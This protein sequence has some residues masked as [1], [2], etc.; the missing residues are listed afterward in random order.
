MSSRV[1]ADAVEAVEEV[2]RAVGLTVEQPPAGASYDLVLSNPLGGRV[3]IALKRVSLVSA[4]DRIGGWDRH[5][6]A[7]G[8]VV[9]DRV[10]ADARETLR[11]AGW[12]WLDLRG[13]LRVLGEGL[14]VD[15]DVPALKRTARKT[16]PLAGQVG[17]EVAAHLLLEPDEPAMVRRAAGA[18]HR[19][20]SSVSEVLTSMRTAGLI[21]ARRKP[22]VPELFW[23]LAAHWRTERADVRALPRAGDGAANAVLRIGLDDV[24]GTG[25]ALGDTVAAATYGAPVSMRSDHHRDFYVP[26]QATLQRALRLLEPAH[27]H[28]DRAATIRVAPVPMIC[29]NRVDATGWANEEWPLALPLFVAL[30]LAQDPGRGREILTDWTPPKQWRR[31]W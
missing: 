29:S 14:F 1:G 15:T 11:A 25:W 3:A 21:D 27:D 18:L 26:D 12:G 6:S 13:H 10:T 19:A 9:A 28:N 4:G 31:V 23:E 17:V 20:P 5:P 8:V 24:G 2:A 30:D 7:V 22:V 16:D